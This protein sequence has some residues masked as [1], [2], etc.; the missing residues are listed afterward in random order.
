MNDD[1]DREIFRKNLLKLTEDPSRKV[2]GFKLIKIEKSLIPDPDNES[3]IKRFKWHME[4]NITH[5]ITKFLLGFDYKVKNLQSQPTWSACCFCPVCDP[6]KAFII[7]DIEKRVT[8]CYT[9]GL[10]K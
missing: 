4:D 9:C 7:D 8:V 3:M 1:Q 2:D 6:N 10:N 5:E